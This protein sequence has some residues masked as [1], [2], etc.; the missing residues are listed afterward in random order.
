MLFR[1]VQEDFDWDGYVRSNLEVK[2][3][4][5]DELRVCCFACG[6][7]DFKLYVNPVK[8]K[9]NCF[10]CGFSSGKY[11][12]FDFVSRAEKLPKHLIIKRLVQEYARTTPDDPMLF[13]RQ[14]DD[15]IH[16][17]EPVVTA[18]I[19]TLKG[20]PRTCRPLTERTQESAPFWDYLISRG[21][22]E[23]EIRAIRFHFVPETI[24]TVYDAKGRRRGNIGRRVVVPIYGGDNALVSWQA[25]VVSPEYTGNDK[26]LTAPESE[27]AKTFWPYVRPYGNRAILVE[28]VLDALAVRRIPE[29]SAYATFSKKI[30]LEQI[31]L[32]KSWGIEEVLVFWDRKDAR[33]E[34]VRAVPDLHMHFNKVYVSRMTNWPAHKDAGNML[35]EVNG[36]DMLKLALEDRVDTYDTLEY[37]KWQLTF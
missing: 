6:D 35:A 22:T 36:T 28:G 23:Y 2:Y 27:L 19:K 11:D 30:S 32:L 1:S 7:D 31:L 14:T 37:S 8:K 17:I 3:T 20:L 29:T 33:K 26:Y 18:P 12:T 24:S 25:R 21:L 13:I 15:A 4:P 16:I 34:I 9:F 5:S 10:K